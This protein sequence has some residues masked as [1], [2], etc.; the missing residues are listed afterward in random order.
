MSLSTDEVRHV[1]RLAR[2]AVDD[3]AVPEIAN[4]LNGVLELLDT[5]QALDTQGVEP[6]TNPLDRTQVLRADAVTEP[7]QRETLMQN[8]PA[9]KDGLFLVPKVID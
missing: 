1:A 5:M 9:A 3:A 6:L 2:L 4:K 8:A 7:N